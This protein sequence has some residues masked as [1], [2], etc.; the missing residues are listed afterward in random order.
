MHYL[1]FHFD[2]EPLQTGRE[3][4]VYELGEVGFDSFVETE[5]GLDGVWN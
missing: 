2:I 1:A 5:N 4:L 3:I